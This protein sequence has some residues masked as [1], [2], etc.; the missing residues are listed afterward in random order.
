ML[1][2]GFSCPLFDSEVYFG[3]FYEFSTDLLFTVWHYQGRNMV[4][5]LDMSIVSLLY[6][7][8]F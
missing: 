3:V 7:F 1:F 4:R 2:V 6:P 5:T 8:G